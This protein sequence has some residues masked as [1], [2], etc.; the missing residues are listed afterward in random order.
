MQLQ[1]WLTAVKY[2]SLAIAAGATIWGL[3]GR[4]SEDYE[5]GEGAQR[6]KRKRLTRAGLVAIG[7]AL[8]S[9]MLGAAAQTLDI[10][11]AD[12]KRF[13]DAQAR[14]Q[15]ARETAWRTALLQ[16]TVRDAAEKQQLLQQLGFQ[17]AERQAD[18]REH[19]QQLQRL[20]E[21]QNVLLQSQS[22]R[23]LTFEIRFSNLSP[24]QRKLV[25]DG[26]KDVEDYQLD[27]D[28]FRDLR[29]LP[30]TAAV[31]AL[32][33]ENVIQPLLRQLYPDI[34]GNSSR[35][36]DWQSGDEAALLVALDGTQSI[37]LPIG[38]LHDDRSDRA[39]GYFDTPAG[40]S[41]AQPDN[42]CTD[43][44]KAVIPSCDAYAIEAD[45][46]GAWVTITGRI[47]SS[48]LAKNIHANAGAYPTA[49]IPKDFR[50]VYLRGGRDGLAADPANAQN[51][52][53][54]NPVCW[55]ARA[56]NP[57]GG[58]TIAI[59]LV[60]NDLDSLRVRAVRALGQAEEQ[61][62]KVDFQSEQFDGYYGFCSPLM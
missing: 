14:V 48:C 19:A 55:N 17:N 8:S 37:V 54:G 27:H 33:R 12:Q 34:D 38:M 26:L 21:Q 2:L 52:L 1:T 49:A 24:S 18:A 39:H 57:K 46:G 40:F 29:G 20:G 50:A 62:A 4:L 51:S 25:R 13:A 58:P 11:I 9:A 5:V 23:T 3:T 7:L 6:K 36:D 10:L 61:R 45:P 15:D 44:E 56:R 60:P 41:C 16:A 31:R 22:L 28:E 32:Q 43:Q 59:M 42:S 30:L 47:S 35:I 53:T